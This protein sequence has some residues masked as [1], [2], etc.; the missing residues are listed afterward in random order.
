MLLPEVG[1]A[2][3]PLRQRQFLKKSLNSL[4]S[5][6]KR[7]AA[8]AGKLNHQP[9]S[10]DESILEEIDAPPVKFQGL[11][12]RGA[13]SLRARLL[14]RK[15]EQDLTPEIEVFHMMFEICHTKNRMRSFKQYIK[16]FHLR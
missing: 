1:G 9:S 16:D 11:V 6:R 8:A 12:C 7:L 13:F 2:S 4:L 3:S 10:V 5:P 15:V 14:F